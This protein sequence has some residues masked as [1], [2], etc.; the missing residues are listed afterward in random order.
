MRRVSPIIAL[1][2][3]IAMA[4]FPLAMPQA[5]G[6][7]EAGHGVELSAEQGFDHSE[8]C[9]DSMESGPSHHQGSDSQNAGCCGMGA[10]HVFQVSSGQDSFLP[11]SIP[12][13]LK[14]SQDEQVTAPASGRL[15][16]P[17]RTI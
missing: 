15:D 16:R 5:A 17:P 8:A 11:L 10:C 2:L 7:M 13:L 1:L 12:A 6:R 4:V 3:A 9:D 14:I